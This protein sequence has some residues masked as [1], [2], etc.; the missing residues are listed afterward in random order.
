MIRRAK[1]TDI[2]ALTRLAARLWPDCDPHELEAELESFIGESDCAVFLCLETGEPA[3]FA[4]CALRREYVEGTRGG[5]VGYLEGIY[6]RPESRRQ[7]RAGELLAAC[8][9]WAKEQGCSEFASDCE[10]ANA[11][12]LAFHLG[13]GFAEAGRLICFVKKL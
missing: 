12:S 13:A 5:P 10:L 3:G 11:E 2:P 9:R 7:G 8:E 6:V 1:K 4:H